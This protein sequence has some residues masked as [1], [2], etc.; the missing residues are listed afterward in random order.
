MTTGPVAGAEV[1]ASP[2][3]PD[4]AAAAD[5]A[6]IPLVTELMQAR[7]QTEEQAQAFSDA[8]EFAESNSDDVGYPW[9]DPANGSLELSAASPLGTKLLG[10]KRSTLASAS[11]I[12]DVR[13]SYGKLEAIKHE[14]TT[15]HAKGVPDAD[16][17]YQTA[18]DHKSNRIVITVSKPSEQLF[19]EL[20]NRYGTDAIAIEINGDGPGGS[21]GSR[22]SDS[23]P[24]WGGAKI[25]GVQRN[26]I[27]S[28][29]FS[30][31]IGGTIG[32]AMLTAAHCAPGGGGVKISATTIG[33]VTSNSEENWSLTTGTTYYTG[34][35]TYK[36]DVA[37]I[38][39]STGLSSA[40]RIFRGGTNS[41][42]SSPVVS[43]YTR[44]ALYGDKVYV[45]GEA[46]GETG[47]YV[48]ND[49]NLD[50]W[51]SDDGP[52]VW[53]RNVTKAT[54]SGLTPCVDHG[55]SGGSVFSIVNGGVQAAGTFSGYAILRC[56]ILFTEIYRSYLGLPGDIVLN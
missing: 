8:L 22:Q 49:A 56:N 33:S 2:P 42:T 38:R 53:V 20:A 40:P 1:T 27:C 25:L 24:Y 19:E 31:H 51:Y 11:Q 7:P 10:V 44:Y 3:A 32:N 47:E 36:G 23:S 12:R 9:I 34:Q 15:L 6:G 46:T 21:A 39:L 43:R 35:T 13:F 48:V 41:T 16:L 37:L 54:K 28:D 55:D 45:G 17:I 30:W 29:S 5:T 26:V 14:V 52:D 4:L 18:P 50:W